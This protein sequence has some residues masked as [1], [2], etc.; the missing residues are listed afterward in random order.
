M[1]TNGRTTITL[2]GKDW[3]ITLPDF[4]TREDVAVANAGARGLPRLRI[5][6]AAIGLC[7]GIGK[8]A[9]VALDAPGYDVMAYGRQVYSYIREKGATPAEVDTV[10]LTLSLLVLESVSPRKE[11]VRAAEDFTGPREAPPT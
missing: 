9:G 8:A 2:L 7:T 4:A 5:Y 10:G 11:E 1:E 6:A 3:P